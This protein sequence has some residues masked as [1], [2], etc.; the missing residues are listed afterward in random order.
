M[1]L[2]ERLPEYVRACFTGIWIESHE[3][4]DALASIT[5]LCRQE[6]WQLATWNIDQGLRVPGANASATSEANGADPLAA[7][8]A[9]NSLARVHASLI[10]SDFIRELSVV[11]FTPSSAAA[12]FVP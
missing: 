12:P 3:H 4:Q 1:T 9:V 7:I 2:L 10:P 6:A 11:G 5:Q 8:R